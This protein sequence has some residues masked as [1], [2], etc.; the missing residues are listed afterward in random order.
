MR[1]SSVRL[2][3][4]FGLAIVLPGSA[5]AQGKKDP[6]PIKVI[7][8]DRKDPVVYEKDIE[9][10]FYKRCLSCHSGKEKQSRFDIATYEGLIKGGKRGTAV[11]PGKAESSLLYKLMGRTTSPVMPPIEKDV[12][13]DPAT[14]EELALVKLWID[15]GAKAP[16]TQRERP[17][18]VV[19]LPPP[20][21]QPVRALAVSPDKAA[22]AASRGNQ[23]HI[24]DAGSGSHIRTLVNPDL[25]TPD[26][27]PV[28]AA[29]I[30]IV[31]SM[32]YSPDGKW[33][34]SGSF[35][36]I[37]IWDILTGQLRQR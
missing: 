5:F 23:I 29:H 4:L 34:V 19:S 27:K 26:G 24:Y 17:K 22:V 37:C 15:Q 12:K 21:V 10:I 6:D 35:Q 16:T 31:D 30:S 8:L 7:K 14:P 2:I 32:A 36:E 13:D 3:A 1:L 18:V 28:K 20:N 11:V 25:K 33:L 9:P